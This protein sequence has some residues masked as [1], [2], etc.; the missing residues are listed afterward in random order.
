MRQL[1]NAAFGATLLIAAA[2][3]S[4]SAFALANDEAANIVNYRQMV[5]QS[6]E[7]HMEA[8]RAILMGDVDYWHQVRDHAVA[9]SGMSRDMPEMYPHW[10]GPRRV[11]TAA[12]PAIWQ[13]W[14]DFQNA[15]VHFNQEAEELVVSVGSID[16]RSIETQFGRVEK[17]C[18]S[19]HKD[20][21]KPD[22]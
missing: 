5:M 17:A 3:M 2:L 12:L 16:R 10:T 8:V 14:R 1:L 7:T 11:E 21:M 22:E 15:A 9:I 20:F 6:L 19:C 13:N 18:L 4:A